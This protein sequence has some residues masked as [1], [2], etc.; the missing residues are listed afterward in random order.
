MGGSG[1]EKSPISFR[2]H[3]SCLTCLWKEEALKDVLDE[4]VSIRH[5]VKYILVPVYKALAIISK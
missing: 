4:V 5:R 1:G 3:M 2:L